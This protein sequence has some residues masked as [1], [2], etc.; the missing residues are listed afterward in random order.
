MKK[1]ERNKKLFIQLGGR[2]FLEVNTV[3]NNNLPENSPNKLQTQ[4]ASP[5][6]HKLCNTLD[7]Y[8]W[9]AELAREALTKLNQNLSLSLPLF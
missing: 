1:P 9:E 4:A 6:F 7:L 8:R 5:K 2:L 3:R